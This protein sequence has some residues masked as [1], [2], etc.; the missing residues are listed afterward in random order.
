MKTLRNFPEDFY[1]LVIVTGDRREIPPQSKGDI[2]AYSVSSTD[3][4]YMNYLNT[5]NCLVLSDKQFAI[6]SEV[7]LKDKF[8]SCNL[9]II[10]SPAVNI[11]ARKINELFM[12]R[13]AISQETKT[14]LFE[15]YDFMNEYILTQDDLNIYHHCLDGILDVEMIIKGFVGFDPNI[16]ALRERTNFITNEFKKTMICSNLKTFP[17]PIKYLMH[18]LDKPGIYDS[19]ANID[20]GKAVS[21]SKDYGLIS[22]VRN[23]F[24]LKDDYYIIYVAG[25]HGPGTAE[26]LKLLSDKNAFIDHPFGGVYEV[27]I[28]QF[29]DFF[30]RIQ[31]SKVRWETGAYKIEDVD[32][33]IISPKKKMQVFLSSPAKTNDDKQHYFNDNIRDIFTQISNEENFLL[34][35]EDPYSIILG[36]KIDFWQKILSFEK[37]CNF[38][39]HDITNCVNGVMIEI[40]FSIGSKKDYFLIWNLNKSPQIDWNIIP[41]LLPTSNIEFININEPNI[42][43]LLKKKI[44]NEALNDNYNTECLECDK[45]NKKDSAQTAFVYTYDKDLLTFLDKILYSKGIHRFTEE[46]SSKELRICK[47]CENM[48]KS[49]FALIEINDKDLNSF[50]VL[51][52]A[53][54]LNLK[55]Q[56]ISLDKY[57]QKLIPWAKDIIKY[58]IGSIEDRLNNDIKKF[59]ESCYP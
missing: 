2:L 55:T 39:I 43:E 26:G 32:S 6:E 52:L 40:G 7:Q 54:A 5:N 4:M 16:E 18:K 31:A 1:P 27:I 57:D 46:E 30:D 42:K 12:F 33:S 44:F 24:A 50:I 9:L 37:G 48:Q 56:P 49:D 34:N 21:E 15:Q 14:E 38:I 22:I 59:I 3:F 19:L 10:G 45:I 41:K 53:K 8:G 51:G 25:V 17:K 13:F 11:L 35:F 23:P 47:F 58:Q 20:R 28:N 36:G 29:K